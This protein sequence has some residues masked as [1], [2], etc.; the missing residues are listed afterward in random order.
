MGLKSLSTGV[1]KDYKDKYYNRKACEDGS[2]TGGAA[3]FEV[4]DDEELLEFP[5]RRRF[6]PPF[7]SFSREL[8]SDSQ[9]EQKE[10]PIASFYDYP[11]EE[12]AFTES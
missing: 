11:V 8:M 5:P 12:I 9:D 2:D 7:G 1:T 10:P 6:Q 4:D 3:T